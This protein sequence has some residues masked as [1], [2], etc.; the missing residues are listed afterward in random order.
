[1]RTTSRRSI[2]IMFTLGILAISHGQPA[3][4][5]VRF[6]TLRGNAPLV[7]NAPAVPTPPTRVK[8]GS[9]NDG[10]QFR[11]FGDFGFDG[12]WYGTVRTLLF[13]ISR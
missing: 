1:M 8:G 7:R 5:G 6:N 13:V 10:R 4:A 9:I 11:S 3:N 12:T 2:A